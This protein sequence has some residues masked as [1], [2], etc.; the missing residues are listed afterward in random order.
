MRCCAVP[1]ER[2]RCYRGAAAHARRPTG[3]WGAWLPAPD[4]ES[5]LP[6]AFA[7]LAELVAGGAQVV[8]V[9]GGSSFTRTLVCEQ[10]RMH[11][12]L[13]ALLVE[14]ELDED[15]AVTAVLSG[16]ADLVARPGPAG[17]A[18]PVDDAPPVAD[19]PTTED[20]DA[21]AHR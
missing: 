20:A 14:D 19:A 6:D 1:A 4:D 10:V 16:R 12:H 18:G 11:H 17:T 2:C 15:R 21:H 9:H 8:A 5:G 3:A 7:L 13:P